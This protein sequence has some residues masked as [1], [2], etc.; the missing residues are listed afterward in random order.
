ME[1]FIFEL[2]NGIRVIFKPT[3]GNVAHCG[4]IINTG[5]RDETLIE[6]G[7]AHFIEHAIFKG[8]I[9]RKT[10]HI[11]N[12]IDSVGGEINAFTTKENTNIY[13]SFT[14]EYFERATDLLTD[15][16]F[17]STFP[18]KEL[19][20]EK[21]V[22]IDEIYSYQDTPYEQ[23]YDDFEEQI[24]KNHP[25]GMNI[26]GSIESISNLKRENVIT[27]FGKHYAS[28]NIVF[29]IVGN[30]PLK[31]IQRITEK[32]IGTIIQ[33]PITTV[34]ENF[35]NYIPQSDSILKDTHQAHCI[36][37]N[38]AYGSFHKK[39]NIFM[40][41]NNILGGPAMNSKLNMGLRE[42]YGLTY[43]IESSY[44]LYSDVGLFSVY[45][46][47]DIKHIDKS[48][49]LVKKEMKKLKTTQLSSSQLKNAKRQFLG[50][51]TIA[52]EN[53]CNVMLGQGKS[54]L[55][56]NKV[57]DLATVHE[58]I[59]AITQNDILDVANEI[60][61]ENQLSTLLYQPEN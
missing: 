51:T 56:Y 5:S 15:I 13:A 29:S 57:E 18:D 9:K 59:N 6:N 19:T 8:T 37:G 39:R 47:T 12:R 20:K 14:T 61:D 53:N 42:K 4:F 38:V 44:N 25:L 32:Y 17:N 50:Q 24:F 10:H 26:L 28:E 16:I 1:E 27:F 23:I 36:I 11:L 31:K 52:E 30:I 58:K 22:I 35:T 55:L 43:N 34:R 21:E 49:R 54:L 2:S 60:F 45:L 46:G 40:L 48:I 3:T 7:M 33:K 41:L